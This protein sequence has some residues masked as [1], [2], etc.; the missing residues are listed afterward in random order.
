VICPRC[1]VRPNDELMTAIVGYLRAVKPDMTIA[2]MGITEP[3]P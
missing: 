3:P 1:A 2:E